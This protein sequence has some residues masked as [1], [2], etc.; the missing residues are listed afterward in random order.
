[1]SDSLHPHGLQHTRLPCPSLSTTVCSNSCPLNRCCYPT[2]SSSVTHFSSCP[3]S[4]SASESFP[5][6]R[7]FPSGS[8]S[9]GTSAS[10]SALPMNI[11]SWLPL[12][13]TGL[14]SVLSKGLL[15]HH[16]SKASIL[17]CSD[18]LYGPTLTICTWL[19]TGE[20][21]ALT[22]RTFVGKWCLCF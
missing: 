5:M 20:V 12:G 21:I 18:L 7:L 2:I 8:Q 10:A 22:I 4:F 6:S 14:I 1:M 17:W 16:S 15:Q 11:Q 13:L 3:Q 19:L 9:I